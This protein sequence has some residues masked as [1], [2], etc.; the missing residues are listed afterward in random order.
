M[1]YG[2]VLQVNDLNLCRCFYRDTLNLGEPEIDST[3][4][5]VFRLN[6][7]GE[8]FLVL[9]KNPLPC[10]E[11][12]SSAVS[13]FMKLP[14]A[15]AIAKKLECDGYPVCAV[16]LYGEEFFRISDPEGNAFFISE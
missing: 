14:D 15:T 5:T 12:A 9:Q 4:L 11:H 10:L 16:D 3:E 13:W 6:C 8:V 2:T 7:D 1:R